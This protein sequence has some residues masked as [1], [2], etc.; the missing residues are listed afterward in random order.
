MLISTIVVL[1][2]AMIHSF[3]LFVHIATLN[4]AMNSRDQALLSLLIGGNF[5]EIKS[6]VFKKYNK[7]N[8]FKITT[9]DSKLLQHDIYVTLA[10][11]LNSSSLESSL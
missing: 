3:I 8:L 5:A 11:L 9:S 7:Q 4:V 6:T 10:H 1:V 2:Y